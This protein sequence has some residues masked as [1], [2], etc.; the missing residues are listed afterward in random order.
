MARGWQDGGMRILWLIVMLTPLLAEERE[1]EGEVWYDADGNVVLVEGPAAE[2][3]EEPFV[4]EWR[5]REIA[6]RERAYHV[7]PGWS[8]HRGWDD[9]WSY[10]YGHAGY[11]H[12]FPHRGWSVRVAGP[13]VRG[14]F[15][16]A[17][18]GGGSGARVIL[19][20]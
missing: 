7:S 1:L 11:G 17:W 4:P 3:L 5:K 10:G 2:P 8:R 6:R 16:G 9:G 15:Y 14:G 13:R 20:F 18:C 12:S 19:R